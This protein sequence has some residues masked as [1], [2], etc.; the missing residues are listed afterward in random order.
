MKSL[1]FG[2][3]IEVE[4]VHYAS[5]RDEVYCGWIPEMPNE[6]DFQGFLAYGEF[7]AKERLFKFYEQ[8][9]NLTI[10]TNCRYI[11]VTDYLRMNV[12]LWTHSDF[13]SFDYDRLKI[14]EEM[15]YELVQ[16]IAKEAETRGCGTSVGISLDY[17]N[18]FG[19]EC[20][21][22][23][24]WDCVTGFSKGDITLY[25][26][27]AEYNCNKDGK[28]FECGFGYFNHKT[29]QHVSAVKNFIVK[30]NLL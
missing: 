12:S 18:H 24:W 29:F 6:D 20:V 16:F 21:T 8:T 13:I 9:K 5:V 26:S 17:D 3:F 23:T 28:R 22:L 11:P 2:K 30:E 10:R 14:A 19:R 1:M 27:G 4:Q 7:I 25:L 15:I